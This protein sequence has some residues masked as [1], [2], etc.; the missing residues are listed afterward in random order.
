MKATR[1]NLTFQLTPLGGER[2][3]QNRRIRISPDTTSILSEMAGLETVGNSSFESNS[4]PM[5][6]ISELLQKLNLDLDPSTYVTL[7]ANGVLNLET[8]STADA[9]TVTALVQEIISQRPLQHKFTSKV[10]N[11]PS[12]SEWT[13]PDDSTMTDSQLQL[14]MREIAQTRGAE[15]V[16]IPSMTSRGGQSGKVEMVH[17]WIVPIDDSELEFDTHNVG[18]VMQ[19]QGSPLGFGHDVAFDFTDTTAETDPETGKPN[20]NKR[21]DVKNSGFSNDNSTR[22]VVQT[23]PDGSRAVVLVTSTMIDATGR[24]LHGAE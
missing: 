23:R 4:T 17:E 7:T 13:P 8:N 6:P 15:L 22:F 19:L 9:E 3:A 10:V 24:P 21:I 1:S 20:F 5:R 14:F 12:G 2:K 11:L 16:T 18:Q